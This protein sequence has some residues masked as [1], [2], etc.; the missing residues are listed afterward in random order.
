MGEMKDK[1]AL[2]AVIVHLGKSVH[3]G[4]YVVYIK[5]AGKWVLFN[6][7]RVTIPEEPVLGKGYIYLYE[8]C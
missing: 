1:Y 4:H 2:K 3:H 5:K 7:D 6:D 8:S